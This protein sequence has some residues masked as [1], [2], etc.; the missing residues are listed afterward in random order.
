MRCS[1]E[2][3]NNPYKTYFA[4]NTLYGCVNITLERER[5]IKS[6]YIYIQ[7]FVHWRHLACFIFIA[8]M[9]H[10]KGRAKVRFNQGRSSIAGKQ[11]FI[12][13]YLLVVSNI[14]LPVGLHTF[15]FET[16]LPT[17]C[18]PS[19]KG[20]HGYIRYEA[21]IVIPRMFCDIKIPCEFHVLSYSPLP[22]FDS[23]VSIQKFE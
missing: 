6:K 13:E 9:I 15:Q 2:F 1:V 19:F 10:I 3:V 17:N 11:S 21:I 12:D 7:I 14:R 23:N 8:L 5:Y 18:P 22:F 20:K 4:G 16:E